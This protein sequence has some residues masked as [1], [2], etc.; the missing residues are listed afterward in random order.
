M[1]TL[2]LKMPWLPSSK[3]TLPP[4]FTLRFSAG[5][6]ASPCSFGFHSICSLVSLPT[7]TMGLLLSYSWL[8]SQSALFSA[9]FFHDQGKRYALA[10]AEA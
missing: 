2:P 8:Q 10:S 3:T 5:V 1:Q 4:G 9:V 6:G 7:P